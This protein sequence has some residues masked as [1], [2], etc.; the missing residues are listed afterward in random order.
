M[1]RNNTPVIIGAALFGLLALGLTAFMLMNRGGG[2][3]PPPV[4]PVVNTTTQYT[5]RRD[6][7]PR[8]QIAMDMLEPQDVPKDKVAPGAV[9]DP[10]NIVGKM[11]ND[12]VPKGQVV[13]NNI[14]ADQLGR[15]IPAF[16][17]IQPGMRAMSVYVDANASLGGVV[18]VGDHVDVIVSH[19]ITITNTTGLGF[20]G[21]VRA[22]RTIAQNL[23]VLAVDR[24]LNAPKPTPTPVPAAPGAAPAPAPPPPPAATPP[25]AKTRVILQAP[26]DV[27]ERL[28]AAQES[29]IIYLSIRNPTSP[30][31]FAIPEITEYPVPFSRTG[32]PVAR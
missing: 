15:T 3:P 1:A 20:T 19:K 30:D 12:F 28:V 23:L 5:A 10:K 13:T 25:P 31:N 27:A 2:T 16:F 26:P 6:I 24:S 11:S 8:T 32:P 18:D 9:T 21:D 4:A 7:P 17:P 22:A 14:V 29:G